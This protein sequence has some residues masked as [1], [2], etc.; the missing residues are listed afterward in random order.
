MFKK[1]SRYLVLAGLGVFVFY[2]CAPKSPP[3]PGRYYN[4]KYGFSVN[5]PSGWEL[6]NG[7]EEGEV[8]MALSPF[9]DDQDLFQE[10]V[11]IVYESLPKKMDMDEYFNLSINNCRKELT[12]FELFEHGQASI[13]KY[14]AKRLVYS[15]RFDTLQIKAEAYI[16]MKGRKVYIITCSALPE[17]FDVYR[18]KFE[19]IAKSF[20]IE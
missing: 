8:I 11:N 6:Q 7:R 1:I 2:G 3:E 19:E 9:S 10:C 12:D 15:N 16:L 5:F 18:D 14:E 20:R 17:Q 4:E 13:G